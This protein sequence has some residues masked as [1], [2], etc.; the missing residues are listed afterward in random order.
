ME[1]FD[2]PLVFDQEKMKIK[3]SGDFYGQTVVAN[4]SAQMDRSLSI[5]SQR[6]IAARMVQCYNA[7]IGVEDPGKLKDTYDVCKTLR[8]D[9]Y[10]DLEARYNELTIRFTVCSYQFN[11]MMKAVD[12]LVKDYQ[13]DFSNSEGFASKMAELQKTYHAVME[14]MQKSAFGVGDQQ[15]QY[16]L[17]KSHIL[18]SSRIYNMDLWSDQEKAIQKAIYELLKLPDYPS[19][20]KIHTMLSNAKTLLAEHLERV[21]LQQQQIKTDAI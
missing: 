21:R 1:K 2:I 16:H 7:M 6:L 12:L 11:E 19:I 5:Q 14:A 18:S 3:G 10:H 9:E 4:V 13:I 17:I 8:L 15:V 20:N